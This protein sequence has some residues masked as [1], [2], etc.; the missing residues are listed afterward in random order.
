MPQRSV[1]RMPC[2][3]WK[4]L[5]SNWIFRLGLHGFIFRQDYQDIF[6]AFGEA[7]ELISVFNALCF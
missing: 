3:I 4:G 2:S 7:R 6:F 5:G 1:I